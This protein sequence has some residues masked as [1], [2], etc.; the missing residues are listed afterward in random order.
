MINKNLSTSYITSI[1]KEKPLDEYPRPSFIRDSY[2]SLNG[3]WDYCLSFNKN[4]RNYQG[5][6]I[7]PYCVESLNSGVQKKLKKEQYIIYRRLFNL[8]KNFI[9]DKVILNILGIDQEY[10]IIINTQFINSFFNI[11][12]PKQIDISRYINEGINEIIIICKDNL[13]NKYPK[14]KQ[15]RK[16]KGMF[17][18]SVSGIYY[19]I[20]IE[21][22]NNDY[23][24]KIK[25]TPSLSSI[26]LLV[27]TNGEYLVKIYENN[28]IIFEQ[29][30]SNKENIINIPNP[31]IW[32]LKDPF[33]YDI[34]IETKNDKIKSYFALRTIKI[35]NDTF[36]LNNEKIFLNGILD[37]G[38]Y[39]EGI[40]TVS[41]YDNY[42]DD[43]L[44]MK[45][46][47]FNLIRKHIKIELDY[48]YYLC[49]KYGMLV[50]QD[51]VNNGKY[52]FIHDTV[53]PTLGFQKY[54]DNKSKSN[55]EHHI[56]L[57]HSVLT[58]NY[59]YNHPCIIGYTI[60]NEGWGQYKADETYSYLKQ[61]DNT[62]FFDSTSGWFKQKLTDFNSKHIYFKKITPIIKK[63]KSKVFLS[64]FGGYSYK[65]L[66]HSFNLSK[67][68]GYKFLKKQADFEKE[69]ISLYKEIVSNKDK[70]I[71]TIYTQLSDVEDETNGLITYDRKVI[72]VNIEKIKELMKQLNN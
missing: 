32:T 65:I 71:G 12:T 70:L 1:N 33:L 67:T 18:T 13:K 58:I 68:Y 3:E 72:K 47:G 62:R 34:T 22:Y 15:V 37:Q 2:L 64:E 36:Y 53:L 56:F 38:Y 60:Y 29:K 9:K 66:N 57:T 14:G 21:S 19:P 46:L 54:N 5:K 10:E 6:I 45:E 43:I 20:F 30:T 16:S 59:L 55:E 11:C 61:F 39:P 50:L 41:S 35:E 24:E 31:H 8:E 42:K 4:D 40:Y 27:N 69:F 28:N 44:L 51:F 26:K 23:I 25:I 49:D 7:V 48:F 63:E 52:R 17:Y